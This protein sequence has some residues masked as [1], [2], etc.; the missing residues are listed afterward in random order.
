ME[1]TNFNLFLKEQLRDPQFAKRFALAGQAWDVA[2]HP[3][4]L[5]ERVRVSQ[6][7]FGR[8]RKA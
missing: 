4:A 1:K 2:I 6:P 7:R 8:K 3:V 5:R